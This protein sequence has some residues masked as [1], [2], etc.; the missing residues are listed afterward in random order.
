MNSVILTTVW[1]YAGYYMVIYLAGLKA[2]VDRIRTTIPATTSRRVGFRVPRHSWKMILTPASMVRVAPLITFSCTTSPYVLGYVKMLQPLSRSRNSRTCYRN[3]DTS[4]REQFQSVRECIV[5]R[6]P[7]NSRTG[8]TDEPDKLGSTAERAS[9]NRVPGPGPGN[10][11][12]EHAPIAL[13]SA[14]CR[15]VLAESFARIFSVP[16]CLGMIASISSRAI[17]FSAGSLAKRNLFSV[18]KYCGGK[19]AGMVGHKYSFILFAEPVVI[20]LAA[21]SSSIGASRMA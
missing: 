3:R 8:N 17:I 19:L 6:A 11:R 14:G 12:R 18:Y 10:D 7:G 16:L 5:E 13:G 15:V 2:I 20:P 1:Q 4:T 21:A 9:I